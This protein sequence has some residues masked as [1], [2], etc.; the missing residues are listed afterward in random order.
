LYLITKRIESV[1][2]GIVER[3]ILKLKLRIP[4]RKIISTRTLSSRIAASV[5][6]FRELGR[7]KF[8]RRSICP[9]SGI[10]ING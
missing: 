4:T 1:R 7:N 9:A 6:S 3:R 5:S 8:T 10:K 2:K